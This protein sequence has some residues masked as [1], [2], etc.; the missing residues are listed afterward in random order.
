MLSSVEACVTRPVVIPPAVGADNP[1]L[2]NRLDIH[3]GHQA[4][5][6]FTRAWTMC[7]CALST[8]PLRWE[9]QPT[10]LQIKSIVSKL[11]IALFD[12][13]GCS[14]RIIRQTARQAASERPIL[15]RAG[16]RNNV[17][18]MKSAV[19]I[20]RTGPRNAEIWPLSVTA[21]H[22]LAE[23]GLLPEDTELLYGTVYRKMSKSPF[24]STLAGQIAD[25]LGPQ[26]PRGF[27][28][29]IEQPI[30]T[31]LSE[32]EPDL[33]VIKG[34]R[35]E[36][37]REHPRTAELVIEICVTSHDYDRS[38]LHAYASAGVKECWLVLGP[39]K[40]IE[41]YRVPNNG[42]FQETTLLRLGEVVTSRSVPGLT[43]S[44]DTL[45]R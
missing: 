30:V 14:V 24:H 38:K 3:L 43:V 6:F 7:R 41:T 20:P 8:G 22:V 25:L 13:P 31:D 27:F 23:A 5:A 1:H 19:E 18:R 15:P 12:N 29:R 34:S 45:F 32:P 26:I 16:R 11:P 37:V 4:P 21:Y 10:E 9:A 36:F 17:H 44:L 39:E 33:A 28:L 35:A 2:N 40:Q 42:K